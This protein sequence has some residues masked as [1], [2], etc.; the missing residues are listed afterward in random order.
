MIINKLDNKTEAKVPEIT[1]ITEEPKETEELTIMIITEVETE[2]KDKPMTE[3]HQELIIP[4][5]PE[6]EDKI[7]E[8]KPE[9]TIE[10]NKVLQFSLET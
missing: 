6:K 1:I 8:M 4:P 3:D 2:D 7:A 5:I 10:A 9:L